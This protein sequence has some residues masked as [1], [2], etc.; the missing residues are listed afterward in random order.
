MN[1]FDINHFALVPKIDYVI[2]LFIVLPL[3]YRVLLCVTCR[4]NSVVVG[5]INVVC[6][7]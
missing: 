6:E 5:L 4:S 2:L 3:H 1:K 7:E